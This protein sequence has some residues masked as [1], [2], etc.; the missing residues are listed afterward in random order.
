[1]HSVIPFDLN[2]TPHMT[3]DGAK[4]R[5]VCS[6]MKNS[7]YTIVALIESNGQESP[8]TYTADGRY[9][10][11]AAKDNPRDLVSVINRS[12]LGKVKG[13]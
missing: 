10:A 11:G 1:M 9:V 13:I 8:Q 5:V 7:A 12:W 3:R 4:A 2:V 6:D